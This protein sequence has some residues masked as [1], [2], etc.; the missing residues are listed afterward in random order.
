MLASWILDIPENNYHS[1]FAVDVFLTTDEDKSYYKIA[2][3][4]M[5]SNLFEE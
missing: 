5:F 1:A 3:T 4:Y 2:W